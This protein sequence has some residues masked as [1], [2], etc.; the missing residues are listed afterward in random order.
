MT[1]EEQFLTLI[2]EKSGF[3]DRKGLPSD[4]VTIDADPDSPNGFAPEKKWVGASKHLMTNKTLGSIK[5]IDKDLVEFLASR[6][7]SGVG[8]RSF[9]IPRVLMADIQERLSTW[10][11]QRDASVAE[12]GTGSWDAS[13]QDAKE[14]LGFLF[15]SDDYP[16]ASLLP[17]IFAVTWRFEEVSETLRQLMRTAAVNAVQETIK[18]VEPSETGRD[19]RFTEKTFAEL[20]SFLDFYD[21]RQAVP[22]EELDALRVDIQRFVNL[23]ESYLNMREGGK[24]SD[25]V[26]ELARKAAVSSFAPVVENASKITSG[27]R[28]IELED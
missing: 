27:V 5:T 6:S 13:I 14:K 18:R 12:L 9:V 25:R 11:T 2:I 7:F 21:A 22:D 4:R 17:Q 16:S 1:F 20:Q 10:K 23:G 3:T 19:R 8:E 26:L 28:A 24:A 15:N